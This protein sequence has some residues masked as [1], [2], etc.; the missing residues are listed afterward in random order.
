MEKES[1]E[2]QQIAN[3]MNELFVNIKVDREERPDVDSIYMNA[4]Q[5]MTGHGGWPMSIFM[6]PDGKPFYAGTYFPPVD[7]GG[8]PGFPSVLQGVAEAYRERRSEVIESTERIVEHLSAQSNARTAAEPLTRELLQSAYGA[9]AP[10]FDVQNGGFGRAPKFP[11]PMTYEFLLRHWHSTRDPQPL[12][13]VELTLQKMACGG[14]YDQ[15]GGGF[16]RYSTDQSWLVPHFE[17]MLYDNTLLV[18]LYVHAYQATAN[19][20]YRQIVEETL[21]Y[22]ER[23][24]LDPAGGFY[25]A[26]DADSEGEE[27]KFFVWTKLD[28]DRALGQDTSRIIRAYYGVTEVGNFEGR[29][30][31]WRPR[32]DEEVASELGITVEE[33]QRVVIDGKRKLFDVRSQRVAPA[34]DDKILTSWNALAL[35]AFA[36]AGAVLDNGHYIDIAQRNAAFLL[37][38]LRSSGRLLRTWKHGRAKLNAY[39]EDYA[40]LTE[41]LLVLYEATFEDRWLREAIGLADGM[42]YL[43]WDESAGVFFDT[44]HDH[45]ELVVRPRDT[46]DNAMPSGGSATTYSLLRL[47]AFT[48]KTD[49]ERYAVAGIRSVHEYLAR[50]PSGFAH[51]LAALDF[52]LSSPKEIAIVGPRSDAATQG[53]VRAANT[54]YLPNRVIVGADGAT[55]N[56]STPLLEDRDLIAGNPA[57]YVCEHYVCLAPVTTPEELGTQLNA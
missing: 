52:Y 9:L 1:F 39:L 8:M 2:N 47:A 56:P 11:Q 25:S 18:T 17:K 41:A 34:R 53:L 45:E 50:L 33:L 49:Y 10:S 30:V 43:F 7:R 29:N 31:L 54:R 28:V 55:S 21:L 46:F 4:V 15:L 48:G 42:I 51:W 19:A 16:H 57:A 35:K 27:G 32:D 14:M 6:T 22:L 38:H 40:F 5:A 36:E 24:V 3:L 26:Q 13:M 20:F 23:E 37:E 44:G 12:A